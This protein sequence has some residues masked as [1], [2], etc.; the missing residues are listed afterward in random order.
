M[1]QY[2]KK[3]LKQVQKIVKQM[4]SHQFS[5][6]SDEFSP[7]SDDSP[8][9]VKKKKKFKYDPNTYF[10]GR[11]GEPDVDETII[12][13]DLDPKLPKADRRMNEILLNLEQ[14]PIK[15]EEFLGARRVFLSKQ[16]KLL[17]WL[18]PGTPKILELK[19]ALQT[20]GQIP[21]WAIPLR[22]SFQFSGGKL[23]FENLEVLTK[24]L[25]RTVIKKTYFSPQLPS[26]I[27]PITD[28][29]KPLFANITRNDVRKVLKSLYTYQINQPRRLPKKVKSK[30]MAT[31]PGSIIQTDMFFPSTINGWADCQNVLVLVDQWSRFSR[32]Y[33]VQRKNYETV[34]V[35]MLNF[36][37]E[38]GRLGVQPRR[39]LSDKGT[40][41]APFKFILEAYRLPR[42]GNKPMVFHSQTGM[43]VSYIESL[44]SQYER[45]LQVFGSSKITNDVSRLLT[46]ISNQLN[47]QKIPAKQNYTPNELIRMSKIGVKQINRNYV[48]REISVEPIKRLQELKIGSTVRILELNRKEQY[49]SKFKQFAPKWSKNTYK[50]LKITR[51]RRNP[52]YKRYY[53]STKNS[54]YRWELLNIENGK[55]DKNVPKIKLGPSN[56]VKFIPEKK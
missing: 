33:S 10:K 24:E 53:I 42:D 46:D 22:Q 51:V 32:A 18:N 19:M 31:Y 25:K 17:L 28:F 7:L 39:G 35:G 20:N 11:G 50:V 29:L 37:K 56:L 12:A 43:P 27:E 9:K 44:N 38:L 47:N 49:N 40:D 21:T 1:P 2:R 6:L 15:K 26:T 34:K 30:F 36:F 4:E 23:L 13:A 5:D 3:K 52:G 16:R 48:G 41:L 14:K 8:I 54:Y 45:R 55:V